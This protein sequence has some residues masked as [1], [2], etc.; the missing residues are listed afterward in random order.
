MNQSQ[1]F[2][3]MTK[4]IGFAF[5]GEELRETTLYILCYNSTVQFNLKVQNV[6]ND[7]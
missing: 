4:K 6:S 3:Q 2:E 1:N 7:R 5:V